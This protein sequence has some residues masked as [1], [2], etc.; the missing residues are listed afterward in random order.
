MIHPY[1]D[2]EGTA[3][4]LALEKAIVELVENQ[5]IREMTPREYVVGYLI[6]KLNE[7]GLLKITVTSR[8]Q[9]CP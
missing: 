1:H 3:V 2:F 6:K 8:S 4:W 7:A 9:S 5:D